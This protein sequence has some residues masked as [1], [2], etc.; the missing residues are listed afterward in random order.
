MYGKIEQDVPSFRIGCVNAKLCKQGL[1]LLG[2]SPPELTGRKQ[3][4]AFRLSRPQAADKKTRDL[5]EHSNMYDMLRW[6]HQKSA[7]RAAE[8]LSKCSE[9]MEESSLSDMM[10]RA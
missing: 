1:R 8:A 3:L 6:S 2:H 7:T 4:E 10:P 5:F 9:R